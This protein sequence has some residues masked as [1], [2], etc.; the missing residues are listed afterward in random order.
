ME[1]THQFS[2]EF[3]WDYL[4]LTGVASFPEVPGLPIDFFFIVYFKS[5]SGNDQRSQL[6][7]EK[8]CFD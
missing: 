4:E 3:W 6:L 2:C 8:V 5:L 7:F 1:F